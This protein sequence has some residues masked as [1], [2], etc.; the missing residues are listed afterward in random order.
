MLS[1]KLQPDLLT[2]NI[3]NVLSKHNNHVKKLIP[4]NQLLVYQVEEGWGPLAE[5]LG[6]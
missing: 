6:E 1:V 2:E 4:S 5:F 3:Q